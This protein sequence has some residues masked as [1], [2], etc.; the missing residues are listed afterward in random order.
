[1][2]TRESGIDLIRCVG[3][4]FVVSV[5]FFARNGFYSE[6]QVG[7]AIWAANS[8]RWLFFGCNGI[9]MT[10]TGYLK[11]TKPF[12]R[13]YYR[14]LLP[15]LLSYLLTCIIS[16]PIRHFLM[17][18]KLT[19]WQ[20]LGK[21]ASFTDYSWYVEM[22][23]GLFLLSPAI[24]LLLQ[25]LQEPKE[26]LWLAGTM[27]VL[28]ALPSVTAGT[29]IPDYWSS[30]YPVTY[31]V[32]GAVIRRL[33][34]KLPRWLCLAWVALI[35]MGL[36]FVSLITAT[37]VITDGFG[38]GYGGFWITAMVILLFLGLYQLPIG[39]KTGKVL[40]WMAGGC[41]EG[42]I[43]SWL[44]DNWAYK[45]LPQWHTPE[46]YPLL[47]VTVTIPIFVVS[48]LAG[49]GVHCLTGLLLRHSKK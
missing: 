37:Q 19:L 28:T 33:Q 45:Q 12:N 24:N 2:K 31:Y 13:D 3:L 25:R 39:E 6:P 1:M 44:L 27:V 30:L 43:L 49:K 20:W 22:Y 21:L 10:L 42:Y 9:F 38:Q 16:F 11:S 48:L 23:I 47:F 15:I 35:A 8:V 32:L 14:S 34:P 40:G 41:F 18:E 26:L 46:K 4:F 36:G 5:H 7:G 17:G 29:L